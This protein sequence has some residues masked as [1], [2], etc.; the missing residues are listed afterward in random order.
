MKKLLLIAALVLFTGSVMAQKS[1]KKQKSIVSTVFVTDV[2]CEGCAKKIYDYIP[3]VRGVKDVQV[4]VKE[5]TVTVEYDESKSNIEALTKEFA[6][7]KVKVLKACTPE[8]YKHHK[9]HHH[10]NHSHEGHS[11]NHHGHS[12]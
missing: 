12:H 2:D 4:N 3:F 7:V 6:Y 9:E 1:E 10:H 5:R 8:E 11:H